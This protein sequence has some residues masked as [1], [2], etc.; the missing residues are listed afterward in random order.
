M[1]VRRGGI[2]VAQQINDWSVKMSKPERGRWLGVGEAIFNS[3]STRISM[4]HETE[5]LR[6]KSTAYSTLSLW[7][8]AKASNTMRPSSGQI[9][10]EHGLDCALLEAI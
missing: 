8:E 3:R 1:T 4:D 10:D 5:E 2:R 9:E 7:L 6:E